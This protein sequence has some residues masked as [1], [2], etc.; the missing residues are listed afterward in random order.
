M[1]TRWV[2]GWAAAW[3]VL[4]FALVAWW[5]PIWSWAC[6]DCVPTG[7]PDDF[8]FGRSVIRWE[9]TLFPAAVVAALVVLLAVV[10]VS[11]ALRRRRGPSE[12]S[13]R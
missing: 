5:W 8:G 2:L 3:V 4:T 9:P 12:V 10:V 11:W 13:R 6:D 7:N 1:N